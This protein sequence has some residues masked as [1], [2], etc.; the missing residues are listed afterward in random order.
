MGAYA[1]AARRRVRL[2]AVFLRSPSGH[3]PGGRQARHAR[4]LQIGL[5]RRLNS[6]LSVILPHCE[7]LDISLA[8][9]ATLLRHDSSGQPALPITTPDARGRAMIRGISLAGFISA[10]PRH[11]DK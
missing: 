4:I 5:E 11:L 7:W 2:A 1:G 8:T 9:K 6:N 10:L 3:R